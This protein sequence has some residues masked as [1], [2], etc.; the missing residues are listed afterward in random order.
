MCWRWR[1]FLILA[2]LFQ[3][4]LPVIGGAKIR[5]LRL[6]ALLYK[7]EDAEYFNRVFHKDDIVFMYGAKLRLI[8]RIR[9]PRIMIGRG[10]VSRLEKEIE[11]LKGFKVDYINYNPEQWKTADTPKEEL[12]DLLGAV[13]RARLLAGR[14]GAKLSFITDYI[15]LEKYGRKVAP[16]VDL[17]VIQLQRYQRL[18]VEEFRREAMEKVHIVREGSKRVP[19][20]AQLSLAPPKFKV[21]RKGSEEKLVVIRHSDGG[22]LREPVSAELVLRQV[23]SIKDLVDGVGFIYTEESREEMRRLIRILRE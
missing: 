18:P 11:R 8:R 14:I 4:G 7:D 16:F 1:V 19:I 5:D 13:K 6:T 3:S 9:G 10:S 22:K 12:D 20:F 17:F 21:L 2:C 15:L 23:E